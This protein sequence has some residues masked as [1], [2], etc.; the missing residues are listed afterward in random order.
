MTPFSFGLLTVFSPCLSQCFLLKLSVHG[1]Y[2]SPS[3]PSI[4][5]LSALSRWWLQNEYLWFKLYL[6]FQICLEWSSMRS[7]FPNMHLFSPSKYV[8]SLLP[9]VN[10][11]IP[12]IL[13]PDQKP[14]V[15]R[16]LL[17]PFPDI[18]FLP[19]DMYLFYRGL[20]SFNF[21]WVMFSKA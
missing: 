11:I 7:P 3:C 8:C 16:F 19:L 15:F 20:P 13:S 14:G 5:V 4:H 9:I 6:E 18:F 2:L 12:A 1:F 17:L 21:Q 10:I